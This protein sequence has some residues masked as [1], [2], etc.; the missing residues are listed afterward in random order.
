MSDIESNHRRFFWSDA[1]HIPISRS[2]CLLLIA[3]GVGVILLL[4]SDFGS[5]WDI[6]VHEGA[7]AKAYQFYFQ[8]FDSLEFKRDNP[9]VY[10]G[11][12]TDVEPAAKI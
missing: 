3:F 8:G 10:Y 4:S 11:V 7:G 1:L 2:S 5:S 12:L 9:S 6:T